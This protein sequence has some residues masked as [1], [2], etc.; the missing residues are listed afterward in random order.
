MPGPTQGPM[1]RVH[2]NSHHEWSVVHNP[3]YWLWRTHGP[4]AA[5]GVIGS[6]ISADGGAPGPASGMSGI[7]GGRTGGFGGMG[8]VTEALTEIGRI[9]ASR[10]AA[11]AMTRNRRPSRPRPTS[12]RIGSP[13]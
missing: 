8:V 12:L 4:H 7:G 6:A 9:A 5:S 10:I 2:E 3:P 1:E 13:F 11:A